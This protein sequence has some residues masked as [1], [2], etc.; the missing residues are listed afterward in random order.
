MQLR[1]EEEVIKEEEKK[2]LYV[3]VATALNGTIHV[4]GLGA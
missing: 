3:S 4:H 2:L 1:E